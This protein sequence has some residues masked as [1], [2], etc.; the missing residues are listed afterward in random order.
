MYSI[1]TLGRELGSYSMSGSGQPLSSGL[2]TALFRQNIS[3][4]FTQIHSSMSLTVTVEH[5]SINNPSGLMGRKGFMSGVSH[6]L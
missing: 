5:F 6:L 1:A 3:G 4:S 2:P